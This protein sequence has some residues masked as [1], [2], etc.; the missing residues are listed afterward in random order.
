MQ[1]TYTDKDK[2]F[3]YVQ[4]IALWKLIDTD[5]MVEYLRKAM[6]GSVKHWSTQL[7]AD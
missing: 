6:R 7:K 3:C 4:I 2:F 5:Q 1:D